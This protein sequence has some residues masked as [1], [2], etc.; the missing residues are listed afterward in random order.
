LL[1]LPHRYRYLTVTVTSPLLTVTVKIG[2][3]LSQ[4]Y[5][6]KKQKIKATITLKTVILLLKG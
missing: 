3:K 4:R 1:P 6:I 5:L 2:L